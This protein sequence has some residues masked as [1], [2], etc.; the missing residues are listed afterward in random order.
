ME[1]FCLL[2]GVF[3]FNLDITADRSENILFQLVNIAKIHQ[4][5]V[6]FAP[7]F[8]QLILNQRDSQAFLLRSELF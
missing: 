3:Y 6:V 5:R 4:T 8:V 7:L 1:K 2:L